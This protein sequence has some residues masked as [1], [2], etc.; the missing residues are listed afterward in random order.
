MTSFLSSMLCLG[1]SFRVIWSRPF[2]WDKSP[3]SIDC[4]GLEESHAG[5]G[6]GLICHKASSYVWT[7]L[8]S[9]R[10]YSV[11]PMKKYFVV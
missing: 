5:T 10:F 1:H 4:E 7:P 11:L 6:Q 9:H 2:V 3:K 8:S